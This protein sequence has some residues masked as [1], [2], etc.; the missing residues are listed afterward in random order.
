M[1]TAGAVCDSPS[2][3]PGEGLGWVEERKDA[4]ILEEPE[5]R[6]E[7]ALS[8]VRHATV[9]MFVVVVSA[10][11]VALAWC[12]LGQSGGHTWMTHFQ[13]DASPSYTYFTALHWSVCQFTLASMEV[14]P[15]NLQERLFAVCVSMFA[16][17]ALIQP[18]GRLL[19]RL[20][21]SWA[22][23][24]AAKAEAKRLPVC[25]IVRKVTVL[26][27]IMWIITAFIALGW[28]M[29]GESGQHTWMTHAGV[30]KDGFGSK[31]VTALTWA[32][33]QFTFMSMEVVPVNTG[34]RVYATCVALASVV[35][36]Y[37]LLGAIAL[38]LDCLR[39]RMSLAPR[40]A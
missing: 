30:D 8:L 24:R 11:G 25:V 39:P 17:V 27:L 13:A 32:V 9:S 40:Q 2:P 23:P 14:V 3:G 12:G 35:V 1:A 38:W 5:R 10:S 29:L 33:S 26:M 19:I 21:H 6:Q 15:V 16:I 31:Y 36:Q 34:E 18:L 22:Q 20:S 37:P 28:C 4:A 7:W